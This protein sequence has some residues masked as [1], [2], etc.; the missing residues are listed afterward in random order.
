MLN[1]AIRILLADKEKINTLLKSGVYEPL[2]KDPTASVE[3]KVQK[4]L[5]LPAEVKRKLTAYNSKPPHLHDLPKIHKPDMPLRY[6][7]SSI[8]SPSNTC[9]IAL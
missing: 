8:S 4:I 1:K 3:R 7:V 6:V 9:P 5:A 2:S